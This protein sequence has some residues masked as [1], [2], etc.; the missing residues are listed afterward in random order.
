MPVQ[1]T[2]PGVYIQEIASG[3]RAITGVA[4]SVTAFVGRA[5]RGPVGAPIT[6]NSNSD[7]ERMFGGLWV[8][9]PM[10]YSVRDFY[11]NGGSQG[12]IVRLYHPYFATDAD[13]L[14]ALATAQDVAAAASNAA[15][16]TPA[17]V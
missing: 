7:F 8:N 6:I 2:Y 13:R 14:A 4:T 1:T 15:N 5:L 9:G 16:T 10:G 17:A 12:V 3:V 11:L